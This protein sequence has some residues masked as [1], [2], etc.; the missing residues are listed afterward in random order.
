[1]SKAQQYFVR[2]RLLIL[3]AQVAFSQTRK[4]CFKFSKNRA[5]AALGGGVGG[6]CLTRKQP[7]SQGPQRT[8]ER[9]SQ[10]AALW[11][12]EESFCVASSVYYTLMYLVHNF[13]VEIEM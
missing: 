6:A 12:G 8:L 10:E 4:P 5:H 3:L 9:G 13:G 11:E 1:M 2:H 7:R